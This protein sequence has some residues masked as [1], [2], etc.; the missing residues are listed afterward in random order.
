MDS[1]GLEVEKCPEALLFCITTQKSS[2]NK[3]TF[4]QRS[5]RMKC[6]SKKYR[7][8]GEEYSRQK[9]QQVLSI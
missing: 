4:L 2:S 3:M 9:E 5:I 7:Y 8:L 6:G 1:E